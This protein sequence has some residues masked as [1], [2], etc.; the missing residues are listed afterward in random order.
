MRLRTRCPAVRR[1]W[2][3]ELRP[4]AGG[5]VLVCQ[6]CPQS[7]RPLAA[8]SARSAALAHLARHARCDVLPVH[9]R[10]CQCR[11]RGCCWHPRHRGCAG[12]IRLLLARERGGRVWRLADSCTACAA[13]TD[14]SAVVPDTILSAAAPWPSAASRRGRGR[15]PRGPGEQARVREMLSYLA[16]ALPADT[17]AAARLLALQCALRMNAAANVQLPTGILRGLRLGH[18]SEPWQELERARWLSRITAA[19]EVDTPTV[20]AR[21][22]DATLLTQSPARPDRRRAADWALRAARPARVAAGGPL[23]QLA[24]VCLAAYTPPEAGNGLTEV[25][26]MA[27]DCGLDPSAL[28]DVLDQLATAGFL[29]SWN[30]CPDSGDLRW[31]QAPQC[32][33]GI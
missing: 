19:P 8:A 21:L 30:V 3:V 7:G 24:A 33:G 6:H 32:V 26:R 29:A 16:A 15:Q 25:D 22:F 10:T 13:A 14:Q 1:T 28:P 9:M 5:P 23:P 2:M 31:T 17:G 20:A 11:E 12:P 18:C 4:H 27:R